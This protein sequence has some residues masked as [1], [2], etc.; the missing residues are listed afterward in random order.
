MSEI[1]SVHV[2]HV[3]QPAVRLIFSGKKMT[4]NQMLKYRCREQKGNLSCMVYAADFFRINIFPFP[5]YVTEHGRAFERPTKSKETRDRGIS[6][7]ES[8]ISNCQQQKY[9]AS[10]FTNCCDE[11]HHRSTSTIPSN[12]CFRASTDGTDENVR[13]LPRQYALLPEKIVSK[14]KNLLRIFLRNILL[15]F[16]ILAIKSSPLN[17][18]VQYLC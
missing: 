2:G 17:K 11:V 3:L 15:P 6:G 14:K 7:T 18:H 5:A 10:N 4:A 13:P 9:H 1:F 16:I 12:L 8:N